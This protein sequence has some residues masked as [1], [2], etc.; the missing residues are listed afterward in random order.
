[1]APKTNTPYSTDVKPD[2][3]LKVNSCGCQIPHKT[4]T[5]LR[6]SPAFSQISETVIRFSSLVCRSSIKLCRI[7]STDS[8]MIP[9]DV[10]KLMMEFILQGDY[11][12]K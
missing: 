8:L 1:M 11:A 9:T 2:T 10:E 4:S 7:F 12:M 5:V 6:F 3:Y